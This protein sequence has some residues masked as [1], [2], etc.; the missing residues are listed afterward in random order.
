[1]NFIHAA[2][3]ALMTINTNLPGTASST[4]VSGAIT[5]FYSFALV[6]A[7]ILAFGAIVWAGIK[8]A[9][10]RGNPAA[11]SEGKSW[12]TNALLGLLLLAG[13][14]IILFTINPQI[15]NLPQGFDLPTLNGAAFGGG[16]SITT[17]S[18]QRF[19]QG[20][21]YG[22]CPIVGE[23]CACAPTPSSTLPIC[24]CVENNYTTN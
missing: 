21:T 19:C 23:D 16:G 11:E 1:M 4:T 8:Y 2:H 17:S 6:A 10:G 9:T 14:W 7:G 3:A 15:V 22:A 24:S 12:I 13:A 18:V 20:T 5:N